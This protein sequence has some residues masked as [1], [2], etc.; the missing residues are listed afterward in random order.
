MNGGR[1]LQSILYANTEW[2]MV[3]GICHD[4]SSVLF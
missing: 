3:I 2:E 1:E 4:L